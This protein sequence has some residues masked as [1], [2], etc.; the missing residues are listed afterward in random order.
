MNTAY[1]PEKDKQVIE[2]NAVIKFHADELLRQ[3]ENLR[4]APAFPGLADNF[5][6]KAAMDHAL[7][8]KTKA[9]E[10]YDAI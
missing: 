9:N 6:L 7:E 8:I 2:L 10:I 5:A 4:L 1:L 3:L